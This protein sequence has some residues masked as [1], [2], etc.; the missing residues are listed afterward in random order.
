MMEATW[1]TAAQVIDGGETYIYRSRNDFQRSYQFRKF[2]I[3]QPQQPINA[4]APYLYPSQMIPADASDADPTPID[5]WRWPRMAG[6]S[7]GVFDED[8]V[9]NSAFYQCVPRGPSDATPTYYAPMSPDASAD[10]DGG[11]IAQSTTAYALRG[12][13]R[14]AWH[15]SQTVD[16]FCDGNAAPCTCGL[17]AASQTPWPQAVAA[18]HASTRALI[19][20]G[21]FE[22]GMAGWVN[23]ANA[24]VRVFSPD[25][26]DVVPTSGSAALQIGPG[27]GGAY[28]WFSVLPS[29]AYTL[30]A[31]GTMPVGDGTGAVTIEFFDGAN[32]LIATSDANAAPEAST[33]V[34]SV[35][36]QLDDVSP[37]LKHPP[38]YSLAAVTVV[39][40]SNAVTARVRVSKT[41]ATGLMVVDDVKLVAE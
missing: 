3:V 34:P 23:Q 28:Q 29:Q 27:A 33:F 7:F 36:A 21:D 12:A 9:C 15:F 40:P 2:G 4:W 22:S 41:S 10:L 20:N 24:A 35:D 6:V 31:N 25:A 18:A 1:G 32:V 37:T 11:S 5:G 30:T 14:Y 16:W 26:G 13:D 17:P 39:A 19:A 38:M 8:S